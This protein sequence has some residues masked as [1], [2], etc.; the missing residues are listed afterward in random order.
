LRTSLMA[1][2]TPAQID[3]ALE[4]FAVIGK[5]LGVI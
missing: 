5:E 1:T 4:S 2:H 3:R